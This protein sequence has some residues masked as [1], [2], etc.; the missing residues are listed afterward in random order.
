MTIEML[1]QM[2][3]HNADLSQSGYASAKYGDITCQVVPTVRGRRLNF[4]YGEL[5][6]KREKAQTYFPR[7][8]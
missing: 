2:A 8:A 3:S 1:I 4:Y 5:R 6:V 7:A